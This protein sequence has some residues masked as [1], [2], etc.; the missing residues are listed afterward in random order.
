MIQQQIQEKEK[1]VLEL[2]NS[3][4]LP[5]FSERRMKN[6][7][8]QLYDVL[9]QIISTNIKKILNNEF[10][11]NN[12]VNEHIYSLFLNAFLKSKV[13]NQDIVENFPEYYGTTINNSN[14]INASYFKKLRKYRDYFQYIKNINGFDEPMAYTI[15]NQYLKIEI[16]KNISNI[17]IN[18]YKY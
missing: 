12:T 8:K 4:K 10:L 18:I 1:K 15:K 17:V 16:L 3:N 9:E 5:K 14:I 13:F 2:L 6:L 7:E 11:Y